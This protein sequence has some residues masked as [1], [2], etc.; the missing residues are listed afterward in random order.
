VTA[1]G[2]GNESEVVDEVVEFHPL[3]FAR[4]VSRGC[5]RARA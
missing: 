3:M 2:M 4:A 1:L 5:A